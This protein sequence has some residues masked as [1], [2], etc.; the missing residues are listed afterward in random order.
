MRKLLEINHS[1]IIGASLAKL[2]VSANGDHTSVINENDLIHSLDRCNSV[3]NKNSRLA[4]SRI[5][6][7]IKNDLL[8]FCI[9]S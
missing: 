3:R 8:C 5:T 4:L 7:I 6:E 1:L 9:D 2:V